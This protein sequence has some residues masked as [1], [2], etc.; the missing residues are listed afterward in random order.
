MKVEVVGDIDSFLPNLYRQLVSDKNKVAHSKITLFSSF[1]FPS[2]AISLVI[3]F[4]M[5]SI[6]V[7]YINNNIISFLIFTCFFFISL[8]ILCIIDYSLRYSQNKDRLKNYNRVLEYDSKDLGY[9]KYFEDLSKPFSDLFYDDYDLHALKKY[10]LYNKIN[11]LLSAEELI[12]IEPKK[13]NS[14]KYIISYKDKNDNMIKRLVLKNINISV[15]DSLK[16]NGDIRLIFDITNI[17]SININL[18]VGD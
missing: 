7:E 17:D 15:L 6:F 1:I 16:S 4:I 2:L 9:I 18:K 14:N 5:L 13:N 10:K 11:K 12:S 8:L 3:G